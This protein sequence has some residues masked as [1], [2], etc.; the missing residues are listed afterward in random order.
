MRKIRAS[1]SQRVCAI[2]VILTGDIHSILFVCFYQGKCEKLSQDLVERFW[3]F[4]TTLD[5]NTVAQFMKDNLAG[6][7]VVF[8]LLIWVPASC[9]VNRIVSELEL[10]YRRPRVSGFSHSGW[11]YFPK[12]LFALPVT[13]NA[14]NLYW[15]LKIL[16]SGVGKSDR[17]LLHVG[18]RSQWS[19]KSMNTNSKSWPLSSD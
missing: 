5:S 4:I 17:D 14:I 7:V 8:S 12:P 11:L 18:G 13:T 6:T 16:L 1:S 19:L 15:N 9:Y 3:T 10:V 2:H